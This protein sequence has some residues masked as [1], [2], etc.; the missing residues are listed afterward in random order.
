[1]MNPA[2]LSIITAT[3]PPR[4]RGRAI[5]IWAGVS[6][7]ALAIGPLVG[8]L[9]DRARELELDLLHQRAGR[10]RGP[11]R[12]PD[13]HRRV[14]R[15]VG[16]AAPRHAGPRRL[17]RSAS[18]RSPT[19]SS[20][21]TTTAGRRPGSSARS[22]SRSSRWLPS[23]CSSSISER[24]CS[25][26][27]SSG[28]RTFSG[29]N[30]SMLFVGLAMFGTFFFVSLYMQNVL[31]YS[32]VQAGATFLPM[33]LLIILIAP[34][35]GALTDRI[36]SRWLVGGGMTLLAAMLFYYSPARPR[37]SPSGAS[38]P[39]LLLGGVGMGVTM[40][41]I[42]AAAMSAV[43]GRQGGRRL[44][45]AELRRGRSAARSGSP[46][47]ARSSRGA[48][49]SSTASTTRCGVGA[50]LCLVGR[51]VSPSPRSARSSIRNRS[52]HRRSR[53]RWSSRDPGRGQAAAEG[54]APAGGARHRLPRLLALELP[55]RDDRRDRARGGHLRADPLPPLR[56]EARPLP[57]VPRRGVAEPPRAGRRGAP[58]RSGRLPRRGRERVHGLA[59]ARPADRPLDPGR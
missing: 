14:A 55:R 2:T 3:F 37:A 16:R 4:E 45:R 11:V 33:T 28:N 6:A 58:E 23:S 47:W 46:S 43:A 50:A 53:A 34:R 48:A 39:G 32:P 31:G 20:R 5:G 42:T 19:A 7:M 51:G 9:L 22:R 35:A 56:L 57:R 10:R 21:R 15:P 54:G 59:V 24:R 17:G 12:D 40:T 41:P 38:C 8:G 13:L 36:G 1:M 26:C 30:G 44:G 49:T 27:R 18:S 29:A 52:M 25:T